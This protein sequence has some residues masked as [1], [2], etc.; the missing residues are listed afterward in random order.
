MDTWKKVNEVDV[1]LRS[2]TPPDLTQARK[3]LLSARD[4]VKVEKK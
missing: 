2:T 3:A 1:A 4:A